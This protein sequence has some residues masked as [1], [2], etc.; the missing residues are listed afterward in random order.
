MFSFS[1]PSSTTTTSSSSRVRCAGGKPTEAKHSSPIAPE[2]AFQR[3]TAA[4]PIF[5][6]VSSPALL[7]TTSSHASVPQR[8]IPLPKE[9]KHESA[10]VT[11]I[12]DSLSSTPRKIPFPGPLQEAVRRAHHVYQ[13]ILHRRMGTARYPHADGVRFTFSSSL[14]AASS[15]TRFPCL[16]EL[17]EAYRHACVDPLLHFTPSSSSPMQDAGW[18]TVAEEEREAGSKMWRF[19]SYYVAFLEQHATMTHHTGERKQERLHTT[20][21]ED[22]R[23]GAAVDAFTE[24]SLTAVSLLQTW[25]REC[26]LNREWVAA[27]LRAFSPEKAAEEALVSTMAMKLQP[28]RKG[29]KEDNN[30]DEEDEEED[31]DD[32]Q[33]EPFSPDRVLVLLELVI[34]LT[35]CGA[36]EWAAIAYDLLLQF[37]RHYARERHNGRMTS[38][39]RAASGDPCSTDEEEVEEEDVPPLSTEMESCFAEVKRLLLFPLPEGKAGQGNVFSRETLQGTE[40]EMLSSCGGGGG[41]KVEEGEIPM[42]TAPASMGGVVRFTSPAMHEA[43][44]QEANALVF[45]TK[46]AVGDWMQTPISPDSYQEE[47]D[48]EGEVDHDGRRRRK[49]GVV[50]FLFQQFCFTTMDLVLVMSGDAKLLEEMCLS[51]DLSIMGYLVG[52]A[53]LLAPFRFSWTGARELIEHAL[54][55][56]IWQTALRWWPTRRILR[57][58][59]RDGSSAEDDDDDDDEEEEEEDKEEEKTTR[60]VWPYLF[61][62]R[63]CLCQQLHDIPQALRKA[64]EEDIQLSTTWK[65]STDVLSP[66]E[67][68][69]EVE[70]D[71]EDEE[72]EDDDEDD[73]EEEEATAASKA[74]HTWAAS[75]VVRAWRKRFILTAMGS[76][77]GDL[78]AIPLQISSFPLSSS[79]SWERGGLWAEASP[80]VLVDRY[81]LMNS[82]IHLL[83]GV[84]AENDEPDSTDTSSSLST[85]R[86]LDTF[87]STLWPIRL[88]LLISSPLQDPQMLYEE[89]CGIGKSVCEKTFVPPGP[90]TTVTCGRS[91][92]GFDRTRFFHLL[93][94]IAG[95]EEIPMAVVPFSDVSLFGN[96]SSPSSSLRVED[97]LGYSSLAWWHHSGGG[98]IPR[99]E[100][101]GRR[102][103]HL[104]ATPT[105]SETVGYPSSRVQPIS[106]HPHSRVQANYIA[107]ILQYFRDVEQQEE[108]KEEVESKEDDQ[109][110][111]EDKTKRGG[112]GGMVSSFSTLSRAWQ[113]AS[114][115]KRQ[116]VIRCLYRSLLQTA[117]ETQVEDEIWKKRNSISTAGSIWTMI[118]S[119]FSFP[120]M[121][122]MG[123]RSLSSPTSPLLL[124]AWWLQQ[125]AA[126]VAIK[127]TPIL[128]GR[129]RRNEHGEEEEEKLQLETPPHEWELVFQCRQWNTQLRRALHTRSLWG[130]NHHPTPKGSSGSGMEWWVLGESIQHGFLRRR[131]LL[132]PPPGRPPA[133]PPLPLPCHGVASPATVSPSSFMTFGTQLQDRMWKV[134]YEASLEALASLSVVR[135]RAATLR[136]LL[137]RPP[138]GAKWS[139]PHASLFSWERLLLT[140]TTSCAT[141]DDSEALTSGNLAIAEP[142][143]AMEKPKS[144]IAIWNTIPLRGWVEIVSTA[145]ADVWRASVSFFSLW[146]RGNMGGDP[147]KAMRLP[148]LH[149]RVLYT[150]ME[151]ALCSVYLWKTM[152]EEELQKENPEERRMGNN[153]KNSFPLLLPPTSALRTAEEE[154]EEVEKRCTTTYHGNPIEEPEQKRGGSKNLFNATIH[155]GLA[156]LCRLFECTRVQQ[157]P[158]PF[159]NTTGP[160]WRRC[161]EKEEE[162]EKRSKREAKSGGYGG[163]VRREE[164]EDVLAAFGSETMALPSFPFS[165]LSAV[166]QCVHRP[167]LKKGNSHPRGVPCCPGY[168]SREEEEEDGDVDS[169]MKDQ[170]ER[171]EQEKRIEE[172]L[173]VLMEQ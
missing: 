69:G 147:G 63:L 156:L 145:A 55:K 6:P 36:M 139:P 153:K 118:K 129:R 96:T 13:S 132:P 94:Y 155:D 159:L 77:V 163:V 110:E 131:L 103:V 86:V 108:E 148:T 127:T 75:P 21:T 165:S 167:L 133:S 65:W 44:K 141:M 111:E 89:V 134:E 48:G 2:G 150:L 79:S 72:K 125:F 113:V 76:F 92:L 82:Y 149:P 10:N 81:R 173:R 15:G 66:V 39:N 78:T 51:S 172:M 109:Q 135:R 64:L 112:G 40:Y 38:W 18:S 41:D 80:T 43:W 128:P 166:I 99:M 124:S 114:E 143:T 30:S 146:E 107:A 152:R 59:E 14:S 31:D 62:R 61:M 27:Q 26:G 46:R 91:I 102:E 73:E 42:P 47:D 120:L 34:R 83:Q 29:V 164:D 144:S 119:V 23:T 138:C 7:G 154:E 8:P 169:F 116:L 151:S 67:E 28:P 20:G 93:A 161:E 35:C 70:A 16:W 160:D 90:D 123:W 97:P 140:T 3:A 137:Q 50:S 136:V 157:I 95:E 168:E 84:E 56:K 126:A 1:F 53:T 33:V 74:F 162:A 37:F 11:R 100:S 88:T 32:T 58:W 24:S 106:W 52:Y 101:N 9:K 170:K 158:F 130:V 25:Y 122:E 22:D 4:A 171:M 57:Q 19:L 117:L 105:G 12:F 49:G 142:T 68:E 121:L 115:R 71:E 54:Q 85:R 60:L 87:S 45:S 98:V 17:S 5:S 104:S